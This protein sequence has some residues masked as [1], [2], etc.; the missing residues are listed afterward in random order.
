MDV[1]IILIIA[2]GLVALLSFAGGIFSLLQY[3]KKKNKMLL[4][5]GI[6]LTFIIP[7][8][9]ICAIFTLSVPDTTVV[10]GP[11]PMMDYGPPQ[12]M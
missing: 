2:I 1:R 6:L 11:P 5:L 10:Y 7:G 12:D 9:V 3:V 8:L 4:V